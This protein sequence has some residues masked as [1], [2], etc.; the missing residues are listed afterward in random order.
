MKAPSKK[1]CSL[2]ILMA[3]FALTLAA[4][5]DVSASPCCRLEEYST[6]TYDVATHAYTLG[7]TKLLDQNP[8][9]D[10]SVGGGGYSRLWLGT[11]TKNIG[12]GGVETP[13]MFQ[14]SYDSSSPF[15]YNGRA[16]YALDLH[17]AVAQNGGGTGP[18]T[19]ELRAAGAALVFVN[20]SLTP[21]LVLNFPNPVAWTGPT[22][23][24][25]STDG[26]PA[27]QISKGTF[28]VN[29][30]DPTQLNSFGNIPIEV[31]YFFD[32]TGHPNQVASGFDLDLNNNPI[33]IPHTADMG[34]C[35]PDTKQVPEPATMLLL[36]F[37]LVGMGVAAR[38]RFVK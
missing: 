11:D 33:V 1:T 19:I 5:G 14:Q 18:F 9:H 37:G 29:F 26:F 28:N 8:L 17:T 30:G 38:R 31:V 16:G 20:G 10:T 15:T 13:W 6:Y 23:P 12:P 3:A 34:P 22:F 21:S 4:A 2:L 27:D 35:L 24:W 7:G 25:N 36:G 32:M